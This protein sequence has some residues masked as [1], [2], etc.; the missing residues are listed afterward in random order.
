MAARRARRVAAAT[1][2]DTGGRVVVVDRTGSRWSTP[3]RGL[4]RRLLHPAGDR[5]GAARPVATGTR[6]SEHARPRLALR[7]RA[8]RL[9]WRRPRGG[10]HHLSDL[11][12]R[13]A[14]AP[15]LARPD[16]DRGG[17]TGV[18]SR[19]GRAGSPAGRRAAQPLEPRGRGRG[20]RGSHG[21]GARRGP[22][23]VRSVALAFNDLVSRL[24]GLLV[25]QQEFVADASH[26][27]RT[28]LTALR[29][30]LENLERDVAAD[31]RRDLDAAVAEVDRLGDLVDGL[32]ALARADRATLQPRHSM[33][34]ASSAS[35]ST[36]G[37]RS[38]RSGGCCSGRARQPPARPRHSGS[39]RAGLDDLL[40]NALEVAPAGTSIDLTP[41]RVEG[42]GRVPR[43]G[44]GP[45]NVARRDRARLRP[46]LEGRRRAGPV[47]GLGSRSC[48][49][50]FTPTEAR[51]AATRALAAAWRRSFVSPRTI[52]PRWRHGC[53]PR[54]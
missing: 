25:S 31:G 37:R 39:D 46:L 1:S 13:R 21:A 51:S 23:E 38:P 43:P 49:G 3:A 7:R 27:L 53:P 33:S 9:R 44:P 34:S 5:R 41:V 52:P 47:P 50:S 32:L 45:R 26:Q 2:T 28:P 11:R 6:R 14:G 4:G 17:G 35:G 48:N 22:P 20:G 19:A 16:R 36:P 30:R 18:R 29:L 12:A 10:S 42:S 15:L 40:A 24:H 54:G 8:R